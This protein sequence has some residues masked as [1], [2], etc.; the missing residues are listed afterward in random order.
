M[1]DLLN[2]GLDWLAN[3]MTEHVSRLVTYRRGPDEVAVRAIIGRRKIRLDDGYGGVRI[4]WPDRDF[5]I[6]AD[7]LVIGGNQIKP[8]RGDKV[9]DQGKVYEVMVFGREPP[10]QDDPHGHMFRIHTKQVGIE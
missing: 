5:I 1:S 3:Q 2:T 9:I 7:L 6:R 10:C 4:E 8:E